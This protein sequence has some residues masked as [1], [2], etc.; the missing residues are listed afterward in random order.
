MSYN[1]DN[2][3]CKLCSDPLVSGRTSENTN[4]DNSYFNNYG[5]INASYENI[6]DK[7][8]CPDFEILP[9]AEA[10]QASTQKDM[11]S[12]ETKIL[13]PYSVIL[14]L[15][16]MRKFH[17]ESFASRMFSFVWPFILFCLLLS[18]YFINY[19]V[20][21][22]D[23]VKEK[24]HKVCRFSQ[25]ATIYMDSICDS[26]VN[27][28]FPS[29]IHFIAFFY[30]FWIFR[31]KRSE[32]VEALVQKCFT[33]NFYGATYNGH[34]KQLNTK[35][36]IYVVYGIISLFSLLVMTLLNSYFGKTLIVS[37]CLIGYNYSDLIKYLTGI[38]HS[39]PLF[40]MHITYFPILINYIIQSELIS[41]LIK[42]LR[43]ALR[44]KRT[45]LKSI[46]QEATD[47]SSFLH[48]MNHESSPAVS[49]M[50]FFLF[51][52]LFN[53]ARVI[54]YHSGK[55]GSFENLFKTNS[56]GNRT[57]SECGILN[58]IEIYGKISLSSILLKNVVLGILVFILIAEGCRVSMNFKQL[59][60]QAM[61]TR[62]FGF[63]SAC[64][65]EL[66]SFHYYIKS[67]RMRA[68]LFQY[69][70]ETRRLLLPFVIF[71]YLILCAFMTW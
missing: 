37:N 5:A 12:V 14:K 3:P 32:Q 17:G 29:V 35:L 62:V 46:M 65:H 54:Y 25:V 51:Y 64:Y 39:I 61:E 31:I 38:G 9:Y 33:T 28:I 42:E 16:G 10:M 68:K 4:S 47:T 40:L 24:Q 45:S 1:L 60:N 13:K 49:L 58:T 18:G 7:S 67:L 52:G 36:K 53:D 69:P 50:L 30:T 19:E 6:G 34:K 26:T 63:K 22:Y 27:S 48:K 71:L 43:E 57:T 56:C 44:E 66:D 59:V 11:I 55:V 23:Q 70:M 8:D 21:Q 41:F 15:L 2:N 20:C